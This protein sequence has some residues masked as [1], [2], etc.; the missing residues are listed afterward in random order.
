MPAE[1]AAYRLFCCLRF[2]KGLTPWHTTFPLESLVCYTLVEQ[3]AAGNV[4]YTPES[5]A[6]IV[7]FW[8]ERLP[9]T[10]LHER[11]EKAGRRCSRVICGTKVYQSPRQL[12]LTIVSE[13]PRQLFAQAVHR[14]ALHLLCPALAEMEMECRTDQ[15]VLDVIG[16]PMAVQQIGL[17]SGSQL[18]Q[19]C[20]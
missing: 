3:M 11:Q 2:P 20:I 9:L 5:V 12:M 16:K 6:T 4:W 18:V 1:R 17:L 19:R 7:A 14:L 15:R 8:R 13:P 10:G